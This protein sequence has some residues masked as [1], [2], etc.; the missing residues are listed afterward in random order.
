MV[1]FL[2]ASQKLVRQ[3]PGRIV[4]ETFDANGER[5]FVMTLTTREQHIRRER[6]TSN[7]CTNQGLCA[8]RVTI[9]LALLGA[10]GLR[11][12]AAQNLALAAYA[13]QRLSASGLRLVHSAPTFNEFVVEV[14]DLH[15]KVGRLLSGG[16]LPGL[17]LETLEPGRRDELLVCTTEAVGRDEIDRLARE[18]VA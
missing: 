18:L 5:A 10:N 12:L 3:L 11:K 6:A 17:E 14:P 8:L 2:T 4:G 1:G 13:K 9:Y 15:A 16:L 7:I